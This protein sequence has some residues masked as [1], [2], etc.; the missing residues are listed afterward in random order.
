MKK[1]IAFLICCL[2][3]VTAVYPA[4]SVKSANMGKEYLE[5]GSY[6]TV[7]YIRP[8]DETRPPISDDT[9]GDWE[10]TDAAESD[11]LPVTK[12]IRWFKNFIERLFAKQKTVTK[13]KYCNYF[14]SNGKLL[15]SVKLKATFTYNHRKAVC[16][17]SEITYEIRDVDWEMLSYSSKEE[18]G[19]AIG[20]F[21][22]R[23]Y[24]LGVPLKLMERIVTITCDKEGNVI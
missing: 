11:V 12:I 23:Q 9:E 22:I 8:S 20:E 10:N 21:S 4:V 19:T 13:T 18:G 1:L 24:K 3:V 17:S 15:W 2:F 16:V 7:T 6:I 14:D 5:D